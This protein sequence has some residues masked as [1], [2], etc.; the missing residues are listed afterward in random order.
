[1]SSRTARGCAS[2]RNNR[3][4][5]DPWM[6]ES[7]FDQPVRPVLQQAEEAHRVRSHDLYLVALD[8]EGV[9]RCL[10]P[11]ADILWLYLSKSQSSRNF[12]NSGSSLICL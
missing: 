11:Y 4:G 2:G 5:L 1:M 9:L 3:R 6:P 8:H 10:S 7:R 12:P